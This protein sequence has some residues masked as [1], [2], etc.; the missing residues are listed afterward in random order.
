ME[1][2]CL[3]VGVEAK[4]MGPLPRNRGM[5]DGQE[6]KGVVVPW[7][8]VVAARPA[9]WEQTNWLE[10]RRLMVAGQQPLSRLA[11]RRAPRQG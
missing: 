6:G 5:T 10:A 2:S 7:L 3:A 4:N 1:A 9:E 11:G 8:V